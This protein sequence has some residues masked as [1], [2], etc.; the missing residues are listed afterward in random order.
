M[1]TI[2]EADDTQMAINNLSPDGKTVAVQRLV[3]GNPDVWLIDVERGVPRRL[4]VA[5][6]FDGAA[7]FS[8]DGRRIAY[9]SDAAADVFDT[10]YERAADGTGDGSLLFKFGVIANHYPLDWSRDGR[11]ILYE[12]ESPETQSD[13]WA[14][15]LTGS[16]QP[17]EIARTSFV[18]TDGRF[19]PDGRWTAYS[20][21][22]A[23]PSSHLCSTLPRPGTEP[24]GVVRRNCSDAAVAA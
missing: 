22:E 15:P 19:S 7:V 10:L 17:I 13:L 11:F 20:S 16:R 6:G 8:P 23:G 4:T 12:H 5:Q 3:N 2:G 14:L 9:M 21:N 24:A 18:E 1:S